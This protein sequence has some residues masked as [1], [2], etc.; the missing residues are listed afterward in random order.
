MRFFSN[1]FVCMP[2]DCVA[3]S[4]SFS[5]D[6]ILS[7]DILSALI[8]I[9]IYIHYIVLSLEAVLRNLLSILDIVYTFYWVVSDFV[10]SQ[11]VFHN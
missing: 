11:L 9:Y 7:L 2:L 4:M 1:I 6:N 10:A 5:D 8:L 3:L